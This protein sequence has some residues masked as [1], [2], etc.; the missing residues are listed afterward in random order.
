MATRTRYVSPGLDAG[1]LDRLVTL[2]RPTLNHPEDEI[3]SWEQVADVWAAVE[4]LAGQE[5]D[6]AGRIVSILRVDVRIRYR[7]DIEAR[8]RVRDADKVYE[9][10]ALADVS[11]R[12]V[13]LQLS[14]EEVL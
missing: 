5:V 10:R 1:R 8:W 7:A 14:C 12:H 3:E 6:A 11:R 4:P 13:Q 9:V 2:L